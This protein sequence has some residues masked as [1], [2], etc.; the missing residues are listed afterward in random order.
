MN[1]ATGKW[2]DTAAPTSSILGATVP[3]ASRTSRYR[4]KPAEEVVFPVVP[5]LDMAFQLLAFFILTFRAPSAETRLNLKLPTTPP[6]LTS[7]VEWRAQASPVRN[8]DADLESELQIRVESDDLG[9]VATL[10]LGEARLIDL[11][12]LGDR[13]RS[14]C[15]LLEGRPLRVRLVA[16]DRLRYEPAAQ[17]ISA[18]SAGGATNFRLTLSAATPQRLGP[19]REPDPSS[20]T[21]GPQ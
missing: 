19:G 9:D 15:R 13:L 1:A 18:C 6:A 11:G 4:P 3:A 17:I 2:M 14:Y 21:G 12:T 8:L 7:S 5:M 10:W 16:D 20:K